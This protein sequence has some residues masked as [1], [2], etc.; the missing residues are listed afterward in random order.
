MKHGSV[1]I[2]IKASKQCYSVVFPVVIYNVV[3]TFDSK[4]KTPKWCERYYALSRRLFLV[5]LALESVDKTLRCDH[6]NESVSR[7]RLLFSKRTYLK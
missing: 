7:V 2:Q 4:S 5:V 1:A 3:L 6:S